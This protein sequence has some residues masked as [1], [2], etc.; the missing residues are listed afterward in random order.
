VRLNAE[1]RELAFNQATIGEI[2][3][4][5]VRSGMRT[6]LGDGKI[7]ILRGDTTPEEVARFAQAEATTASQFVDA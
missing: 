3:D 2:R 7:K 5:S 6:L 1:V 4:A